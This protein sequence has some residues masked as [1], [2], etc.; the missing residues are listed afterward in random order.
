M[1]PVRSRLV[2]ALAFAVAP[3]L[4]VAA[5]SGGDPDDGAP[6]EKAC[7]IAAGAGAAAPDFIQSIGCRADFD[8]LASLPLDSSIPGARSVKFIIDRRDTDALYFQN[9]KKYKIHWE[10]A[11]DHLSGNGKPVVAALT[12][13]NQTEYY[14]TARR[15]I[16]GS[17]TYYEGP[18][19]WA[20]EIA[21]YDTAEP[22]M[23]QAAYQKLAAATYFGTQLYFHPTSLTVEKTAAALPAT[24]HKRTTAEIFK[25]IDYQPLNLATSFGRL[26]FVTANGLETG[27][28]LSFRDI[29]VLDHVPNDISVVMGI[30]TE[31]FQTPLSHVN[32]LSQN[33]KTPNMGLKK[34]FNDPKLRALENKWVKLTVGAFDWTAVETTQAEA[35]A[36][37]EMNK[38]MAVGLPRLDLETRDLREVKAMV[39]D[40]TK[41][42][43]GVKNSIPAFGGKASH[44]GALA[45][46]PGVPVPAGFGIPVYY[47]RQ[48]MQQGG[49]DA[50]VDALLADPSFQN[51]P[52]VRDTK[53]KELRE[54]MVAGTVDPAFLSMVEARI[55]AVLPPARPGQ[56]V[57]FRSSTN[58]EDLEGFTGAGLYTSKTGMP[59]DPVDSYARAIKQVWASVWFFRAFE[60]RS[61]R[62]IDHKSVGMAL[63][64]HR[65][66]PDEEANGVAL[67]SDPFDTSGLV[68]GFYINVQQ[69]ESSVVQPPPGVTTDQFI[70]QFN[71]P[72]QPTIFL[73][74]SSLIPSGQA[75]VL[76]AKQ[77]FE[78]GKALDAIHK[79][80]EPAYGP[81]A[82]GQPAGSWYAMDVEFKFDDGQAGQ[83][84]TLSVKQARPHPGRGTSAE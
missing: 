65:N 74:R 53:L 51:D 20:M 49:F 26:R 50:R 2:F 79:F 46:V 59:D 25:A 42:H 7:V 3:A 27:E 30:I 70:Y 19:V 8:T 24:V 29:V 34:A 57:R 56:G 45:Q 11:K 17:L 12:A 23:I 38:P 84:P 9:S 55:A 18:K 67:T 1:F 78:L 10:F 32:V 77:T 58:A 68:P 75:A 63:L 81:A 54:A 62:S 41:I 73:E 66:F 47:Y 28:Y 22:T 80:F 69:G 43:E 64:V 21:P 13:F 35:D 72:N 39:P 83:E 82:T 52:K 40:A 37:W 76:S 15:F 4:I 36:W 60:E 14:S 44:F 48:Y 33:R 5:C 71:L 6:M 61:Y 31:E 16:L